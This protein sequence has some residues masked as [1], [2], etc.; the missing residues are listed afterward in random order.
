ML[1]CGRAMRIELYTLAMLA[2]VVALFVR[3]QWRDTEAKL[4]E[5][6]LAT[7]CQCVMAGAKAEAFGGSVNQTFN[8]S[9]IPALAEKL[10]LEKVRLDF[11]REHNERVLR[12]GGAEGDY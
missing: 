3:D 12:T 10:G 9:H 6:I 2:I 11:E 1:N 8:Q 5:L 7:R 4:V